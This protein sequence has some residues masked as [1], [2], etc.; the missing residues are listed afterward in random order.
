MACPVAT[1]S[2]RYTFPSPDWLLP[3]TTRLWGGGRLCILAARRGGE[4]AGLAP[5]FFWGFDGHP[6]VIRLSFLGAG[7][8]DY[9]DLIAAPAHSGEFAGRVLEWLSRRQSEWQICDLQ[10]LR[11]CSPLLRA[12]NLEGLASAMSVCPVATLPGSMDGLRAVL[13]SKFRRNLD[14]SGVMLC[15]QGRVEFAR[16]AGTDVP[17]V[18]KALFRLHEARWRER[19]GRGIFHTQELQAFHLEAAR[20]LDKGGVLRLYT[21]RVNGEIIA[22]QYSLAA[23]RRTL[24]LHRRL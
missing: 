21:L 19:C 17:G 11:P 3:W 22:V 2:A 20:G 18:M 15:K 16:A 6:P 7:I 4:L 10:E 24:L 23:K 1:R 5:F 13:S 12:E 9:L 14:R 8:S